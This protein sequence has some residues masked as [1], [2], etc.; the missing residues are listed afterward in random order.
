MEE[1][2]LVRALVST[3]NSLLNGKQIASVNQVL[4]GAAAY[5]VLK[6][7]GGVSSLYPALLDLEQG[8]NRKCIGQVC[9]GNGGIQ[10][11]SNDTLEIKRICVKKI[12]QVMKRFAAYRPD[13][14]PHLAPTVLG[15]KELSLQTLHENI[16]SVPLREDKTKPNSTVKK[17]RDSCLASLL[18]STDNEDCFPTIEQNTNLQPGGNNPDFEKRRGVGKGFLHKKRQQEL[19][20]VEEDENVDMTTGF[21]SAKSKLSKSFKRPQQAGRGE[22]NASR[23]FTQTKRRRGFKPPARVGEGN[24]ENQRS[25]RARNTTGKSAAGG[26]FRPDKAIKR[27]LQDQNGVNGKGEGDGLPQE[28]LDEP[29]LRNL[30]PAIIERIENEVLETSDPVTFDDIAGLQFAKDNIEEI[31]VWP[32]KNPEYYTGLRQLPKG[33]LLFGP[34]G[35]GKTLIGKAIAHEV[36]A[37]FFSVSASSL[38]SKWIGEGEK[39]VRALFG[40][41]AVKQP[42]IVFIDEIDSLLCQRS[43]TENEASRRIKTEFLVQLDGAAT[44]SGEMILVIGATN[45]PQELDEAARRRF[46]KRLYIP[47]PDEVTRTSLLKK[48]LGK[49]EHN[50]TEEEVVQLTNLTAGYSGADVTNLAREASMGPL[51]DTMRNRRKFDPTTKPQLRPISYRDFLV[52][53]KSIRASVSPDDLVGYQAWNKEFGTQEYIP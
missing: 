29:R 1:E 46:V 31:V 8:T 36:N 49:N 27:A 26:G 22:D 14:K 24:T 38:T 17:S 2:L 4:A 47:L 6:R 15:P 33:L 50:L 48:L 11:I 44:Q 35:T 7:Q 5:E 9:V 53:L 10:S 30:E 42:S 18:K 43:S 23:N 34:P 20:E 32:I 16:L 13:V 39:M 52:S 40:V 45:R 51:R 25:Q 19:Y 21:V 37:T 3:E 41:A 28:Y 12:N